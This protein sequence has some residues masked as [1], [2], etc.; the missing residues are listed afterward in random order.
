MSSRA[1]WPRRSACDP[2]V[3]VVSVGANDA[4]R[5]VR[6]ADYRRRLATILQRLV[7]HEGRGGPLRHGRPGQRP[8]AA[9][10]PA[11]AGRHAARES[12][13]TSAARRPWRHPRVVKVHTRGRSSRRLLRGPHAVRRGPVPRR[14]RWSRRVRR[15]CPRGGAGRHRPAVPAPRPPGSGCRRTRWS[16]RSAPVRHRLAPCT[17][18]SVRI[19]PDSVENDTS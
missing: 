18:K 11:A 17:G 7:R 14:G 15:G 6:P 4:L 3:V 5:G 2:D 10:R 16:P 1:S 13:T 8:P 9:H 12:S 19:S